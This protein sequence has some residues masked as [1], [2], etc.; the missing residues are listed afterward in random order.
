MGVALGRDLA[1]EV[2]AIHAIDVV[3][4]T[5]GGTGDATAANG[6][7][8]QKSTLA[9]RYECISFAIAAK[10]VLAD[11]KTL[12]VSAKLQDSP[13]GSSWADVKDWGVVITLTGETGGTTERGEA[14]RSYELNRCRD[15]VRLVLTPNLSAT[16][17][18]TA[19]VQAVG[20]LSGADQRP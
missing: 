11:T 12:E 8:I 9:H 17:T 18:D 20:L 14:I 13:N 6:Q 16:G 10:G 15:Y 19:S 2:D 5:A 1:Y 4:A 3:A 7:T